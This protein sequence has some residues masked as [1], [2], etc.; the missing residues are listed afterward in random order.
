V[1][2]KAFLKYIL[3]LLLFGSNGIVASCIGLNSLHIVLLRT[4]IGSVFLLTLF[5]LTGGKFSFYC[6]KQH[7]IFLFAS[8][9]AM[10]M[11]WI[12]LYEAYTRIGV[13]IA[14]LLYYCGPVF[15][16]A[17]SPFLFHEKL[18]VSKILGFLSVAAGI[19]LVNGNAFD[20]N[21]NTPGIVF[22]LLSAV[23][24]SI[25]VICNKK[26]EKITGLENSALQLTAAFFTTAVFVGAT[27]GYSMDISL[28]DLMPI[29]LLGFM[30]TGIGCWLYFSSIG[31]LQV[32]T[33]AICGYLEPLS[34]VLLSV[35]LLRESMLPLQ[36]FGSVL[37]LGGAVTGELSGHHRSKTAAENI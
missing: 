33:V 37:I 29:L 2:R 10:G 17:L 12:L 25:M 32:Q 9:A 16:M 15:V 24:Y 6:H 26:A 27:H 18:T 13:S 28:S 11:S 1:N 3:A 14:S 21:S 19:V 30:N 23:M 31:K 35:L 8:G 36:I 7:C 22:A 4:F 20:G 34:A 5:L